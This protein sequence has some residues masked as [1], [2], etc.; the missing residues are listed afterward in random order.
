MSS[1][2]NARIITAQNKKEN[3][4]SRFRNP[5]PH[6]PYLSKSFSLPKLARPA[7]SALSLLLRTTSPSVHT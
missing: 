5:P 4:T 2:A 6:V 7:L 1:Q 3:L